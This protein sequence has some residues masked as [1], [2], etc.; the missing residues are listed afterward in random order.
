MRR[1][2]VSSNGF[3]SIAGL[4]RFVNSTSDRLLARWCDN[5]KRPHQDPPLCPPTHH[6]P[7]AN[8]TLCKP[9]TKVSRSACVLARCLGT[10]IGRYQRLVNR[11]S[12]TR[13]L[14]APPR[15]GFAS[16]REPWEVAQTFRIHCLIGAA[17]GQRFVANC[18]PFC[19]EHNGQEARLERARPICAAPSLVR[20][21]FEHQLIAKPSYP[22]SAL[23]LHL[24]M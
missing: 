9:L 14:V 7:S 20:G 10:P 23:S 11:I 4:K 5:R 13:R 16:A 6:Q 17:A 19:R 24:A 1:P 2:N 3:R 18:R 22:R 21:G 12:T 8:P 15:P